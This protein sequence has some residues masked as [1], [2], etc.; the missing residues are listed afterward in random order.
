MSIQE[1][2]LVHHTTGCRK[3]VVARTRDPWAVS[4]PECRKGRYVRK[5]WRDLRRTLRK[6]QV[7]KEVSMSTRKE[8]LAKVGKVLLVVIAIAQPVVLLTYALAGIPPDWW[9]ILIGANC[10]FVAAELW[11]RYSLQRWRRLH[12]GAEDAMQAAAENYLRLPRGVRPDRRRA[13][14]GGAAR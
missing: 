14:E 2:V 11:Q 13:Q 10:G 5:F 4:C 6:A 3:G 8:R 12:P 7:P 1:P 9:L